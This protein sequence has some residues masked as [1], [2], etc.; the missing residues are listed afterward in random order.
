MN[1]WQRIGIYA[2]MTGFIEGLLIWQI[3]SYEYESAPLW[4]YYISYNVGLMIFPLGYGHLLTGL[5]GMVTGITCMF[6]VIAATGEAV[7][8]LKPKKDE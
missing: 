6:L 2:L 1:L 4:L 5:C 7:N 3:F 8:W